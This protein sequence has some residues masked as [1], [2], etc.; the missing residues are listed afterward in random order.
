MAEPHPCPFYT[1]GL[2]GEGFSRLALH[3]QI[4]VGGR[5]GVGAR[6]EVDRDGHDACLGII[7]GELEC[8]VNHI[9]QRFDALIG[10]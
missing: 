2:W 4:D 3:K 6:V 7:T 10:K 5:N 1:K 8:V 9:V